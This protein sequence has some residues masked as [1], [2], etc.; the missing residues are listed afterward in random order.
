MVCSTFMEA[1]KQR[2]PMRDDQHIILTMQEATHLQMPAELRSLFAAMLCFNEVNDSVQLW[3]RFKRN[4]SEDYRNGGA[5]EEEAKAGAYYDIEERIARTGKNMRNFVPPPT[6]PPPQLNEVSLD[7]AECAHKGALLY[8]TPNSQQE[9][10]CNTILPAVAD[11]SQ[12]RL[13]FIDGPGGSGKTYMYKTIFNM[14]TGQNYNVVCT[15]WTGIAA[16]LLPNGRTAA[17]LFKLDISHDLKPSNM[18]RQQKE[19]RAL[20][21]MNVIIWDEASMIQERHCRPWMS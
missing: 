17:S 11:P 10:A 13:F 2:G 19:A 6:I 20:A 9:R 5:S 8:A 1:A 16:N 3:E 12:P 21:E 15:A 18:R 4:L 7:P 14:L